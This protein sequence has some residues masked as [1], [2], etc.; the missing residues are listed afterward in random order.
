VRP[1]SIFCPFCKLI[2]IIRYLVEIL[3]SYS[4]KKINLSF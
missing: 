2:A 3:Y 4:I 1:T